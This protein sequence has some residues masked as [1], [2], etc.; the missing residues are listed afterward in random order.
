MTARGGIYGDMH[1]DGK[2]VTEP[3]A[4][5]HKWSDW[6]VVGYTGDWFHPHIV[7]RRCACGA[8]Q[9]DEH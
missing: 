8:K 9:S 6:K 3:S 2:P 4:H 1:G 7:E 5:T